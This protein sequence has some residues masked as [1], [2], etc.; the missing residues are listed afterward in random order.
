LGVLPFDVGLTPPTISHPWALWIEPV[1]YK[2]NDDPLVRGL[3]NQSLYW[4]GSNRFQVDFVIEAKDP[5]L[6]AQPLLQPSFLVRVPFGRGQFIIDQIKWDVA[7][8]KQGNPTGTV[9]PVTLIPGSVG[10]RQEGYIRQL[11]TNLGV[12]LNPLPGKAVAWTYTPVDLRLLCNMGF[13]DDREEDRRG[14]WTDQGPDK[15]LRSIPTGRQTFG[16]VPFDIIRPETNGGKSCLVLAGGPKLWLPGEIKGIPVNRRADVLCFLHATAWTTQSG[17]AGY[18][19]VHYA[20]GSVE[21]IELV[22][23]ATI[24]EWFLAYA[25]DVQ[26]PLSLAWRDDKRGV[27]LLRWR[28]PHPETEVKAIDFVSAKTALPILLAVTVGRSEGEKP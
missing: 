22:G 23:G 9:N 17:K 26:E 1:I 20:D 15:D 12:D 4:G 7:V 2:I 10:E 27:Y 24:Q 18:Y 25:S 8:E 6:K 19:R 13:A 16:G 14:G 5:A 11:L 28:N 21:R 3:S